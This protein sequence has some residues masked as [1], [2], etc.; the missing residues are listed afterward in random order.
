MYF[1]RFHASVGDIVTFFDKTF[2]DMRSPPAPPSTFGR[3]AVHIFPAGVFQAVP[4]ICRRPDAGEARSDFPQWRSVPSG[5]R[6]K[7]PC[8]AHNC[9]QLC[10]QARNCGAQLCALLT[11][12][13]TAHPLAVRAALAHTGVAESGSEEEKEEEEE[14]EKEKEGERGRG[15]A[16]RLLRLCLVN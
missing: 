4:C 6:L 15:E 13:V 5:S 9:A 16:G 11:N 14:G 10:T 2:W 3:N 1:R 8:R 7:V 12:A